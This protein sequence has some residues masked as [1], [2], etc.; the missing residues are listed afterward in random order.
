MVYGVRVVDDDLEICFEQYMRTY[1]VVYDDATFKGENEED[2]NAEWMS[3]KWSDVYYI[4]TIFSI[5]ES[6]W[7]YV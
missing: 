1:Q 5:A 2:A 7:E 6:I 3:V 4:P